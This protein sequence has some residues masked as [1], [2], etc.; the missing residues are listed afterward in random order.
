M[1]S[2]IGSAFGFLTTITTRIIGGLKVSRSEE[3]VLDLS[4]D[5]LKLL[6]DEFVAKLIAAA[7][8]FRKMEDV[9]IQIPALPRP[10]IAEIQAK[11]SWIKSIERDNSP[12]EAVTLSLGTVLRPDEG[13]VGGVEY[14]RRIISLPTLGYQQAVWLVDHQ[15]EFPEFMALLGKVYID[16][17]GLVVVR[18]NGDR[19]VPYLDQGGKRWY[20]H[21]DWLGHGQRS[22]GRVA[23][24]GK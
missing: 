16:F 13:S 4:E 24:S 3:A 14:E 22:D 9:A 17:P 12:T 2:Q 18:E 10:T 8:F 11:F 6:T 19:D 1:K 20:L 23:V 7:G 15:D 5:T 21:W